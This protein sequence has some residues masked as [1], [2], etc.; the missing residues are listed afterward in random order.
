MG[1]N[2]KK[3]TVQSFSGSFLY[4]EAEVLLFNFDFKSDFSLLD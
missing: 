2:D 1:K 4:P 3:P